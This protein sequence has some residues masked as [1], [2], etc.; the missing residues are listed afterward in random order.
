MLCRR[1]AIAPRR[2]Q[3]RRHGPGVG[4]VPH[5]VEVLRQR[6]AQLDVEG[7]RRPVPGAELRLGQRRIRFDDPEDGQA[8]AL[9]SQHR[10]QVLDGP[11]VV[12]DPVRRTPRMA[13]SSA[14]RALGSGVRGEQRSSTANASSKRPSRAYPQAC[15]CSA[16]AL[17][18]DA[19]IVCARRAHSIASASSPS[20][21]QTTAN[22][23]LQFANRACRWTEKAASATARQPR[24][25]PAPDSAFTACDQRRREAAGR[26]VQPDG[27]RLNMLPCGRRSPVVRPRP[28]ASHRLRSPRCRSPSTCQ[29][30]LRLRRAHHLERPD[31]WAAVAAGARST[32][33]SSSNSPARRVDPVRET[34]GP[35]SSATAA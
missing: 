24:P 8:T 7:G 26:A 20:I 30:Q 16:I 2:A 13:S 9:P 14:S 25:R 18:P 28:P 5:L 6:Q 22:H 31:T 4:H 34:R 19:A 11:G 35:G 17:A 33:K 29:A 27:H 10:P 32:A 21:E 1:N 12:A 3:L 23:A 15:T